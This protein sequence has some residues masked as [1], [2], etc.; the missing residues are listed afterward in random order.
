MQNVHSRMTRAVFFIPSIES[1]VG[2]MI[3]I[4]SMALMFDNIVHTLWGNTKIG[5][6]LG[7]L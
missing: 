5:K 1:K 4:N 3:Q 7:K 2:A 6:H